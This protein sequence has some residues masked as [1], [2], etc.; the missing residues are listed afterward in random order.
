MTIKE[1]INAD[2]IK[3]FKEKDFARK[4]FLGLL[5]SEIQNE[6]T[7]PNAV[8]SD[9]N[10]LLILRRMEKALKQTDSP[11]SL[12]ELQYMEP[13]L[14]QLMSEDQIREIVNGYKANGLNNAGQIMGQFNKE[15]KGL[16]DNRVVSEIVKEV[17]A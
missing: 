6:E 3:A 7:R 4:D 1:R 14:P 9:A 13:Y 11:E 12:V 2:F 5:K 8:S 17:L 16:A 10:T 15:H